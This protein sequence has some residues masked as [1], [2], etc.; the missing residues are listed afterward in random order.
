MVN[1]MLEKYMGITVEELK[2]S[3]LYVLAENSIYY[4]EKYG[5]FYSTAS[6]SGGSSF[7][8]TSGEK[9]PDG[10]VILYGENSI[11]TLKLHQDGSYKIYSYQR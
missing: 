11:L 8:C 5:C 4:M 7:V 3:D 9:F 1:E 10:T 2:H 6:D